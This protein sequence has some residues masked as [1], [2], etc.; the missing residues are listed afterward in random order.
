M[1]EKGIKYINTSQFMMNL[2][3]IKENNDK[4][5]EYEEFYIS[6]TDN[7]G[8]S[9]SENSSSESNSE[10]YFRIIIVITTYYKIQL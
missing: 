1:K 7:E 3:H 4:W 5:H 2:E 8:E 9:E 6:Q 10:S